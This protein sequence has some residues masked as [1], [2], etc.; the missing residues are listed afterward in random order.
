MTQYIKDECEY[1]L[2]PFAAYIWLIWFCLKNLGCV[3]MATFEFGFG[4]NPN[5]N[6]NP[7]MLCL[8]GNILMVKSFPWLQ[9]HITIKYYPLDIEKD[10]Y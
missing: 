10:K 9:R 5:L 7:K 8:D 2:G 4:L 1:L 6:P 3:W